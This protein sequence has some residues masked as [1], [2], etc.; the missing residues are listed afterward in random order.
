VLDRLRASARILGIGVFVFALG[1]ESQR[2][3]PQI[4]SILQT[5]GGVI[6][7]FSLNLDWAFLAVVGAL[8][9]AWGLRR[10][11]AAGHPHPK[12]RWVAFYAGIVALLVAMVSPLDGYVTVSFLAF[13]IQHLVLI[14]VVAP[15]LALGAPVTLA[16]NAS[17]PAVRDRWVLPS[18]RAGWLRTA[19]HPVAA[20]TAFA[21]IQL[22]FSKDSWFTA[23][24]IRDPFPPVERLLS[25]STALLFWWSVAGVDPPHRSQRARVAGASLLLLPEAWLG[26]RFE[27]SARAVV[28]FYRSLPVPWGRLAALDSQ[29]DAGLLILVSSV[30]IVGTATLLVA[31]HARR[32]EARA[33]VPRSE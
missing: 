29:Q 1:L 31:L 23:A 10:A 4:W 6:A 32:G 20:W 3:H 14:F 11:A 13:T 30:L 8:A 12:R 28:S 19:T 5:S 33:G 18:L 15:M 25:L 26:L 24:L 9:Y 27:T 22:A 7:S 16:L 21:A 2:F 17:T